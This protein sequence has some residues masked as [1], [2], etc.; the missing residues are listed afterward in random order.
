MS[1]GNVHITFEFHPQG[2]Q[3]FR[4]G[5]IEGFFPNSLVRDRY[6]R[7]Q[8]SE[9]HWS[10]AGFWAEV[11]EDYEFATEDKDGRLGSGRATI[12]FGKQS[13]PVNW[14]Y[15]ATSGDVTVIHMITALVRGQIHG[16][17]ADYGAYNVFWQALCKSERYRQWVKA[18]FPDWYAGVEDAFRDDHAEAKT[19][20]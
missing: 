14:S 20:A 12:C 18:E 10:C 6:L 16:Q 8:F 11:V 3:P 19:G 15:S 13:P 4:I 1:S 7:F 2:E 9:K 17:A 5:E